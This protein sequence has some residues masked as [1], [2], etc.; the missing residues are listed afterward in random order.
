MQVK[1]EMN[2]WNFQTEVMDSPI[3]GKGRFACVPIPSGEVV[4]IVMGPVKPLAAGNDKMPIRGTRFVIDC[5]QT[6]VNHGREPNLEL[7]G[8]IVFRAKRDITA[9][10][11][12]TIDY[13]TLINGKLPFEE[14][15]DV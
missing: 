13:R 5:E 15:I 11:E 9:G 4:L 3:H 6:Y 1:L 14:M 8:Q 12:L 7:D 10:E 2:H